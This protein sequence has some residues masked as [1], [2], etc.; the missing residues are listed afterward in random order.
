[1]KKKHEIITFKVDED[2]LDA[3]KKVPN[4]SEFIRHAIVEAL[5]LTCPL[6][7]GSGM[8]TPN[9]K[10]HWDEFTEDH[11]IKQC[12]ECHENMLVCALVP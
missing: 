10:S 6:C 2:L 1:M 3:L 9:Q 4:R 8:L 5:G 7:G 12:E 11:A